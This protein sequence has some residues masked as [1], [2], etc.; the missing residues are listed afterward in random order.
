M[1]NIKIGKHVEIFA[2]TSNARK[3]EKLHVKLKFEKV[4]CFLHDPR[5]GE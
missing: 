5:M 2:E 1:M 4:E 3:N